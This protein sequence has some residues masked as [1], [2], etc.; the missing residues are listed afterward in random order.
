ME[1]IYLAKFQT[2]L[3]DPLPLT[4]YGEG[5]YAL[6]SIK[7]IRVTED[8]LGLGERTTN[9]G[10]G[11]SRVDCVTVKHLKRVLSSCH[12][13]PLTALSYYPHQARLCTSR[14]LDCVDRIGQERL[15]CMEQCEGTIADVT[16]LNHEVDWAVLDNF[17]REYDKFKH[18]VHHNLREG[19]E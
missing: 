1:I 4:L 15:D 13:A 6:T 2:I 14:D 12:C 9:C 3:S 18:P 19:S 17:V 7:R 8:F 5:D 10:A 16:K 11:E